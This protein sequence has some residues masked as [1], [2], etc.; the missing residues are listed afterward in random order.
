MQPMESRTEPL[1]EDWDLDIQDTAMGLDGD[2]DESYDPVY[3]RRALLEEQERERE[4][5]RKIKQQKKSWLEKM[6]IH[7][8]VS[9][10]LRRGCRG[11]AHPQAGR[12]GE[13]RALDH[14]SSREAKYARPQTSVS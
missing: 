2:E 13:D 5:Q 6:S 10:S 9:L 8:A 14:C 7:K 3:A 12:T 4:K 1:S 11:R